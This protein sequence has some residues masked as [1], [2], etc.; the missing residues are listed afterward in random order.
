MQTTWDG[1]QMQ[2]VQKNL[3]HFEIDLMIGVGRIMKRCLIISITEQANFHYKHSECIKGGQCF[4][5]L[6]SREIMNTPCD[7]LL[8]HELTEVSVVGLVTVRDRW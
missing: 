2:T 3:F 6:I 4:G 7:F 8:G 1:S 5:D